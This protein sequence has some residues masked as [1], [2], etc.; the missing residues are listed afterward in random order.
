LQLHYDF[1][2][3]KLLL[4]KD[5]TLLPLIILDA[6]HVFII[7]FSIFLID[8]DLQIAFSEFTPEAQL[9][10][11]AA[12]LK[13]HKRDDLSLPE[14]FVRT[15]RR[16][17]KKWRLVF[18]DTNKIK[19]LW[20]K[21]SQTQTDIVLLQQVTKPAFE[22]LKSKL[23]D[24]WVIVPM[25]F[26]VDKLETTAICLRKATVKLQNDWKIRQLDNQNFA[27]PCSSGDISFYVAVF[28]LI[29]GEDCGKQRKKQAL[30]FLRILGRN[31]PV[32]L[33]GEFNEDLTALENTV[34]KIMLTI[35]NGIDHTQEEPLA[36]SVNRT[37]TNLHCDVAKADKLDKG[38][39]DGIFSSFPLAGEAFTD[40]RHS[41]YENPSDHGP[42]FQRVSLGL[43]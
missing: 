1:A 10:R 4:D 31:T 33:G 19:Q 24:E 9:E 28:H 38:V 26:P 41:G 2:K 14:R 6:L 22:D 7:K 20:K 43:F 27:V 37:R 18:K 17:Y 25:A 30:K 42:V 8:N 40:F 36:Y 29:E 11:I 15:R 16:L 13:Q 32:I 12:F 23:Q 35:Y 5:P 21:V 3:C 39:D 34:A